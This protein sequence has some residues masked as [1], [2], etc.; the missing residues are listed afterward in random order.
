LRGAVPALAGAVP[1]DRGRAAQPRHGRAGLRDGRA[2]RA[3][4][5]DGLPDQ[6]QPACDSLWIARLSRADGAPPWYGLAD[7]RITYPD[8]NAACAA[9][10]SI[11]RVR[12][13][14]LVI[15]NIANTGVWP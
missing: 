3:K 10:P 9:R 2:H 8:A 12:G 14:R 11:R 7:T 5:V 4:P 15:D 13:L 6:P 1:P